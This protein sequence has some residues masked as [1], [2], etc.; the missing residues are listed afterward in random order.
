M[1][2]WS[3]D[4]G[5]GHALAGLIGRALVPVLAV[6]A[7]LYAIL[8]MRVSPLL[9]C[10]PLALFEMNRPESLSLHDGV[11][12]SFMEIE[13]MTSAAIAEVSSEEVRE[14]LA[15]LREGSSASDLAEADEVHLT[16]GWGVPLSTYAITARMTQWSE[17]GAAQAEAAARNPR[18][19]E[20]QIAPL[21]ER[22]RNLQ[23][24]ELRWYNCIASARDDELFRNRN[25]NQGILNR[26]SGPNCGAK[27]D[28]SQAVAAV[29][30]EIAT[31]EAAMGR[32]AAQDALAEGYAA[33]LL[34]QKKLHSAAQVRRALWD[35]TWTFAL[36]LG[37]T[38]ALA[39]LLLPQGHLVPAVAFVVGATC[40]VFGPDRLGALDQDTAG[41]QLVALH[42][43]FLLALFLSARILRL[44][45]LQNRDMWSLFSRGGLIGLMFLAVAWWSLLGLFTL[46]GFWGNVEMTK[47]VD[48]MAYTVPLT[49]QVSD[50][51]RAKEG[52]LCQ[53]PEQRLIF[54]ASLDARQLEADIDYSVG[55]HFQ[56][57]QAAVQAAGVADEVTNDL[58]SAGTVA[59]RG[60]DGVVPGHLPWYAGG[61]NHSGNCVTEA[62][63]YPDC[64]WYQLICKVKRIPHRMAERAYSDKRAEMRASFIA[65]VT[66]IAEGIS[67]GVQGA[68]T[69][70]K[71]ALSEAVLQMGLETRRGLATGFRYWDVINAVGAVLF[72][73]A[74]VK[75]FGYVLARLVFDRVARNGLVLPPRPNL[76]ASDKAEFVSEESRTIHKLGRYYMRA[77]G[78]V[79]NVVPTWPWLWRPWAL[80]FARLPRLIFL[81]R[82]SLVEGDDPVVIAR[83]KTSEFAKINLEPSEAISVSIPRLFAFSS[84][85]GLRRVWTFHLSHLIQGRASMAVV[86]GPGTVFLRSRDKI[87]DGRS[88]SARS[89]A[90]TRLLAWDAGQRFVVRGRLT[91]ETMYMGGVTLSGEEDVLALYD[92]HSGGAAAT[93]ALRFIPLLLM[94]I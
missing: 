2:G 80:P 11:L 64:D 62:F 57:L 70:I 91:P 8:A 27:P 13:A 61:A 86:S 38:V 94:P 28:N 92:S 50:L 89:F 5:I 4:T 23:M 68:E 58:A 48:R 16:V 32:N 65:R 19:A 9:F 84:T 36:A 56:D 7:L 79:S 30:A 3:E 26:L 22:R 25:F 73:M 81:A 20:G 77:G 15:A 33:E 76:L 24:A 1:A 85:V 69:A 44:F 18:E 71:P 41:W 87:E 66:T 52:W 45:V 12:N 78:N 21:Q 34:A 93:G 37:A 43:I 59:A 42:S 83:A 51:N 60:F 17:T 90:P 74:V 35:Q 63:N 88:K 39:A 54:P 31:I 40:V 82:F 29:D 6:L 67:S 53:N 55:C 14:V 49:T 47:A 10:M 46:L 75:S 72:A